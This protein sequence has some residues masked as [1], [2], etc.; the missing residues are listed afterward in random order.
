MVTQLIRNISDLANFGFNEVDS[1]TITTSGL[2]SSNAL[3]ASHDI[4]IND[5]AKVLLQVLLQLKGRS[6]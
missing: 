5:Y 6:N 3:T 1:S 4:K 2:V